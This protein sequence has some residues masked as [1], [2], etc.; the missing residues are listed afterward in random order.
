MQLFE[1]WPLLVYCGQATQNWVQRTG[2]GQQGA[3]KIYFCQHQTKYHSFSDCEFF[4]YSHVAMGQTY[5]V[6]SAS[7]GG[8]LGF[9]IPGKRMD[10]EVCIFLSTAVLHNN[11][12]KQSNSERLPDIT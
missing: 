1:F 5:A 9:I 2:K 11:Q 4:V 3:G 10:L 12:Q 7:S 6:T 8:M